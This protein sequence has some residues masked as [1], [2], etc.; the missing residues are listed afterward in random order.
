MP[1]TLRHFGLAILILSLL[2]GCSFV[3]PG[4]SQREVKCLSVESPTDGQLCGIALRNILGPR[5]ELLESVPLEQPEMLVARIEDVALEASASNFVETDPALVFS[6]LKTIP[7]AQWILTDG[8][9]HFSAVMEPG[10]YILC[11]SYAL[12][13]APSVNSQQCIDLSISKSE[14]TKI[15]IRFSPMAGLFV[16]TIR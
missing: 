7:S 4:G 12:P 16:Q 13:W 11:V 3:S 5:D 8:R 6:T 10:E 14:T 9:G 15:M 2:Y 1:H